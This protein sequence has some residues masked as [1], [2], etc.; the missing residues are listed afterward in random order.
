MEA[1]CPWKTHNTRPDLPMER[2]TLGVWA[3]PFTI[4]FTLCMFFQLVSSK[5]WN[6]PV[7]IAPCTYSVY[8]AAHR[9]EVASD[10]VSVVTAPLFSPSQVKAIH[11]ANFSSCQVQSN[12]RS[13]KAVLKIEFPLATFCKDLIS[14]SQP[15]SNQQLMKFT[16]FA[17][18]SLNKLI[19]SLNGN[20]VC[21]EINTPTSRS[22]L[23]KSSFT[24]PNGMIIFAYSFYGKN[25]LWLKYYRRGHS[26]EIE[27]D[28]SSSPRLYGIML[29]SIASRGGGPGSR[30]TYLQS[31]GR[32]WRACAQK[33]SSNGPGQEEPIYIMMTQ[34]VM[35]TFTAWTTA[36]TFTLWQIFH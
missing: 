15:K 1:S 19:H 33:D 6:T 36:T 32:S 11:R 17:S 27:T 5:T 20:H 12:L 18:K 25:T 14:S 26:F 24:L 22:R 31:Y 7:G 21:F 3:R 9:R 28:R 2:F 13:C 29:R 30:W 10:L 8:K 4:R 35:T 34:R 16:G 23:W